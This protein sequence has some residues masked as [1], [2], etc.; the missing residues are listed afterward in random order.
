MAGWGGAGQA[1]P[2]ASMTIT[3]ASSSLKVF[4]LRMDFVSLP[5]ATLLVQRATFEQAVAWL[6]LG[7]TS[8]GAEMVAVKQTLGTSAA[9]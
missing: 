8:P 5:K 2:P 9:T 4:D 1:A 7:L 6:L 3:S